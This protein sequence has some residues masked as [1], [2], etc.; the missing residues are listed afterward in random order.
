MLGAERKIDWMMIVLLMAMFVVFVACNDRDDDSS[1]GDAPDG[2]N[3]DGDE[4]DGD[5]ALYEEL[6]YAVVDTDQSKCFNTTSTMVCAAQGESFF[7]QDAQY[8]G[9]APRYQDNGDG[10]V[11]DRVTG[12]MWQQDP[13]DKMQY[14]DA[15]AAVEEFNLAGYDDWRV[16][17]I[18]ELYSLILFS[19][20]DVD[21]MAEESGTMTPFIDDETFAFSYGD[22]A[23]GERVIDSQWV[24]NSIYVDSV[25]GGEE[26]FFGVNFAD[27]RIK[28]YPTMFRQVGGYYAIFVRGKAVYGENDFSDNGDG[29]I[30]DAATGLMWQ[31]ADSVSTMNWEEAL[32][33]CEGLEL[34]DNS[35]WRLPNA[36]ELQSLV[37]YSRSPGTTNSAAID[38]L[39][40]TTGITNEAGQADF[41][42]YWSATTHANSVDGREGGNAAYVAFG[43]AMGYMNEQ[44]M[45]V[46]GA[47]AQ[48]SDP[49]AGNPDD[50]AEGNG[51]QGDAIRILNFVRCVRDDLQIVND[52]APD[53]DA[54]DGDAPDGD[55]PAGDVPDGDE[56]DGDAPDGDVPDGPVTCVTQ[57]DCEAAQACPTDAALGCVCSESPEGGK[58]CIPS[59][60]QDSDC[61]DNPN[62]VLVC[63]Q[64]GIC[65]PQNGPQ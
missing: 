17:T 1:D 40:E 49:K 7:G 52:D 15:I 54:P 25:M 8:A 44:W 20:R 45:D 6:D 16:P 14:A 30:R 64:Q 31:Q 35:D 32:T 59:C 36:K 29:T 47:G 50:Y 22:T 57:S 2:D 61:P 11:S 21:P 3:A 9:F 33:Y 18:K 34:A 23:N 10:T 5:D 26:C 51:P 28:C 13:G 37:D 63:D 39:F 55:A 27:G 4:A 62:Q 42:C 53:G 58:Y 48:R 60:N 12:L 56:P 24:T 19:G 46:H 38:P 41:G 43:R 65:V